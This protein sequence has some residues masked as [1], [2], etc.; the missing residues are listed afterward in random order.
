[1]VCDAKQRMRL[2]KPLTISF[3]ILEISKSIMYQFHY[4]Y[5]K[6]TYGNN[7]KLLFTD[8]DSF[9]CHI[10]FQFQFQFLWGDYGSSGW[11]A[12]P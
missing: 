9:C 11:Y 3:T 10:Q 5:L 4:D 2:N 7:C 8:M 1:M 6:P 12:T